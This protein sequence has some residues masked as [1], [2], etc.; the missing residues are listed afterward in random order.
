MPGGT[1]ATSLYVSSRSGDIDACRNAMHTLLP[2]A[3]SATCCAHL[4]PWCA[5]YWA[6]PQLLVISISI[7]SSMY[8]EDDNCGRS[9]DRSYDRS[10]DSSMLIRSTKHTDYFAI[11]LHYSL[12]MY[13]HRST[14]VYIYICTTSVLLCTYMHRLQWI[15]I[16]KQSGRWSVS[17]THLTLPTSV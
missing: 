7:A 9:R 14:L 1:C 15:V 8:E 13:M 4:L 5:S 6:G 12:C 10:C 11:T 16:S 2:R 17:Y 3:H